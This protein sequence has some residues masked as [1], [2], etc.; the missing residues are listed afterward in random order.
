MTRTPA[1]RVAVTLFVLLAGGL[2]TSFSSFTTLSPQTRA[3]PVDSTP[4]ADVGPPAGTIVMWSGPLDEIPPGWSLCDGFLGTPD[5]TDRFLLGANSGQ[6]PDEIGG[7]NEQTLELANLPGHSHP[8]S[9]H[10]GATAHGHK[11]ENEFSPMATYWMFGLPFFFNQPVYVDEARTTDPAGAHTHQGSTSEAG[12]G[13]AFDNR[14]AWYRLAFLMRNS[15]PGQQSPLG[16]IMFW[17][18]RPSNVPAG[19]RICDG[20]R[21]TPDLIGRFLLSVRPGEDPGEEGGTDWL[22][23]DEQNLPAHGHAFSS[24]LAGS[25]AHDY[26]EK[27]LVPGWFTSFEGGLIYTAYASATTK[28]HT[29]PKTSAAGAHT[30]TGSVGSRGGGEAIDNRPAYR[31]LTPIMRTV[32]D[33]DLSAPQGGIAIWAG[34]RRSLPTGWRE[35]DGGWG[36]PDLR[37]RFVLAAWKPGESGGSHQLALSEALMPSHD[38]PQSPVV[39]TGGSHEHVTEDHY[40]A[41]VSN[42]P[43]GGAFPVSKGYSPPVTEWVDSVDHEFEHFHTGVTDSVGDSQPFDN[44]PGFA[45]VIFIIRE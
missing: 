18:G 2:L 17:A 4:L 40:G 6:Q 27:I 16:A 37:D 3:A 14:P 26:T 13:V 42:F 30:H 25:H 32:G 44:R 24:A 36:R 39:E 11:V 12:A 15:R 7:A 31:T 23:L 34:N 20:T 19:W 22:Q 38:H 10:T 43:S 33:S 21:G 8:L 29:W 45:R 41:I 35:C 1:C 5:L 9:L 28:T